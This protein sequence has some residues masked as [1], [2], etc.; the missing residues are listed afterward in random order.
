[1]LRR[2]GSP[3]LAPHDSEQAARETELMAGPHA[4]NSLVPSKHTEWGILVRNPIHQLLN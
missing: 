3:L 4:P 1:M 2:S